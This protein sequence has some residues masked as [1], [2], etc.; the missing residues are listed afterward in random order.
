MVTTL[1]EVLVTHTP[2][3]GS[4]PN[5]STT[6]SS[7]SRGHLPVR[8]VSCV[9]PAL[10]GSGERMPSRP[11]Y[12][13]KLRSGRRGVGV[14]CTTCL[15]L[16]HVVKLQPGGVAP[17]TRWSLGTV[18]G[19]SS[20]ISTTHSSTLVILRALENSVET[21]TLSFVRVARCSARQ[22]PPEHEA[23]MLVHKWRLAVWHV[24]FDSLSYATPAVGAVGLG[25][26]GSLPAK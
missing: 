26:A 7:C 2:E 15:D 24:G 16:G 20:I 13:V 14:P 11:E 23:K 22:D 9:S 21:I 6:L 1:V 10:F 4:T 25:A 12:D 18:C 19:R 17:E 5:R 3:L 8:E